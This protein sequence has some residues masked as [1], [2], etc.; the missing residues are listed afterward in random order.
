MGDELSLDLTR[1]GIGSHVEVL[2][3]VQI[4]HQSNHSTTMDDP[5]STNMPYGAVQRIDRKRG[6]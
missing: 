5:N 6:V 4:K 2:I 1:I 3:K